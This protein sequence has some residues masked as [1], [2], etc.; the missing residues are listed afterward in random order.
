MN[1]P[2]KITRPADPAMIALAQALARAQVKRDIAALRAAH[3]Q[4][5]PRGQQETDHADRH[6]R[7][8]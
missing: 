1:A 4:T 8:L 7:A 6:L 3:D 5:V 2:A